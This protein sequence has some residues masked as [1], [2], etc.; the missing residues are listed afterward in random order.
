MYN[1]YNEQKVILRDKVITS[2]DELYQ[3]IHLV[4]LGP[5]IDIGT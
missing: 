5:Y 1:L 2:Y 4:L 3:K